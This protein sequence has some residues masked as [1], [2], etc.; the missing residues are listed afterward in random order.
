[1][2]DND[3]AALFQPIDYS[4]VTAPDMPTQDKAKYFLWTEYSSNVIA[5]RTDLFKD[6]PKTWA[7]VW[8]VT[9]FPGPRMLWNSAMSTL[10]IALMA[11]GVTWDKMYPL[12]LDRAFKSLDKLSSQAKVV[13]YDSGAQQIQSLAT[14]LAVIGE[15]WNG[16]VYKAKSAG[17]AVDYTPEQSNSG[18]TA[19]AVLKTAPHSTAAMKFLDFASQPKP[20]A[21]M[22]IAFPGIS[23]SSASAYTMIPPFISDQLPTNPKN[24]SVVAGNLN[25]EWWAQNLTAVNDRW[26]TWYTTHK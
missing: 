19:W 3:A 8:D 7:D 14:G 6:G 1:M 16:R 5:W 23:P 15:G 10:E 13:W 22:A 18:P 25:Y 24:A 12:D 9:K 21:D 20:Q 2:L 11:D 26:Q 4:V 17:L